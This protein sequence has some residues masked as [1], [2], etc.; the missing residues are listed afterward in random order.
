M[1]T[2]RNISLLFVFFA[3]SGQILLA[4]QIRLDAATKILIPSSAHTSNFSSFLAV[5]NLDTLPNDVKI[6]ARRTDGSTIGTPINTVINVGAKFRSTD[7]LGEMGAVLGDFG[8]IT[9]E[10]TNAKMLSAVSEVSSTQGTAGFFPGVN[11]QSAWMQG[12]IP[13]VIDTGEQGQPGT[14][15]TNLGLNTVGATSATVTVSLH[16]NAGGLHGSTSI[17]VPGNGMMQFRVKGSIPELAGTN[18]Y[19]LIESNQPIH[20]WASKINNGSNDPSFEIGVGALSG[21]SVSQIAPGV[22]DIRNNLL[23]F[24]LA[25][26][27]PLVLT[28]RRT[29]SAFSVGIDQGT[30]ATETL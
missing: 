22:S 24:A 14:F 2:L 21:G 27:A 28:M 9:V 11:V 15:R 13:E 5:I 29:R 6:T 23:F 18:G 7:I 25:L 30:W 20:A 8:P 26:I 16:D 10:S 19:L 1:K 4:Q 3:L 12:F 17:V